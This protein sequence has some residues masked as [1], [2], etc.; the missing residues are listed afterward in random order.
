MKKALVV[1]L[2]FA[3]S[4]LARQ[5]AEAGFSVLAYEKRSHIAGNMYEEDRPNGVR[6][7]VY[8]PHIFHTNSTAV[9][10]YLSRYSDF[11][12]YTHRVLGKLQGQL[13]PIPFNFQSI[14]T[15][16]PTAKAEHLK[17]ILTS[18]FGDRDRVFIS[19]LLSHADPEISELGRFVYEYVF[20]HYTAKQWGVPVEQVDSSVINRVPVML[21]TDD[22]YFSDSIQ[23]MPTDG[24]TRLFENLLDHPNIQIQLQTDASDHLQLDAAAH[25]LLLHG[26]PFP[27]PVC[28]SGPVD[29]LFD[30]QL[31]PLPY[32]SL[33]MQFEDLPVDSFQP[34]AVVNY[35]NEEAFTRI[36]EFK[37]LTM[38]VVPGRTSVLREYPMP[39]KPGQTMS[40]YYPIADKANQERYNAYLDRSRAYTNLYLCG[41]LAEY[42]YY[43]MDAVVE[44]A[45]L[46]ATQIIADFAK[47]ESAQEIGE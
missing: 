30:M 17:Q 37:K 7:H 35:P 29:E 20:V 43:N 39:Y 5:L 45:L 3:G 42:R 13:V 31:G 47:T 8:G 40:P 4:V 19:E 18:S 10:D 24:F 12:P 6:V 14:D 33:D 11:Y 32:R 22:R 16:F 15:L 23:S 34:A 1:G 25:T 21:G 38:Q 44:R 36:T 2:G 41:R 28:Y 26:M 46:T 9:L 27:G